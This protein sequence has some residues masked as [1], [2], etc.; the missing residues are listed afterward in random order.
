MPAAERRASILA[1]AKV[2]FADQG[3]N[4][5]TVDQIAKRVGVTPALLYQHFPSKEALYSAVLD[6]LAAPRETYVEAALD[7]PDDFPSV[8]RRITAV[9]VQRMAEDPDYLR[10]ELHASLEDPD[11]AR[12]FFESRWQSI[13][14]FIEY[15]LRELRGEGRVRL[16]NERVASLMFFGMVKEAIYNKCLL[17]SER[18]RDIPLDELV[19][20]LIDL[21]I[22]AIGYRASA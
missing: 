11:A 18:Y 9:F 8:L 19:R 4:G 17:E 12:R 3:Y 21:F 20:Q 15:S 6:S 1:V 13:A 7:G 2:L 16:L 5:V 22:E 10:M 14:E